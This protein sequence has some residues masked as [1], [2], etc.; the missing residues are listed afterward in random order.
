MP[1]EMTPALGTPLEMAEV[2]SER[3][4]PGGK[5]SMKFWKA[6]GVV[7]AVLIGA[8][9]VAA[10]FG[11]AFYV[12]RDEYTAKA[13]ADAV[14]NTGVTEALKRLESTLTTQQAAFERLSS[15]VIEVK[16]DIAVMRARR[17]R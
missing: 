2:E 9:T 3:H 7:L 15:Q 16:T 4:L 1:H 10:V 11:K 17:G 6:A 5:G 12:T 13:T 8:G 14:T